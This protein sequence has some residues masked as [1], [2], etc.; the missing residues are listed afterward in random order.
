[1]YLQHALRYAC[2]AS[3][4]PPLPLHLRPSSP[5]LTPPPSPRPP[6]LVP[7]PLAC[8]C[9]S[10]VRLRAVHGAWQP[11]CPSGT[12]EVHDPEH[13]QATSYY[14]HL[15]YDGPHCPTGKGF[16]RLDAK[17]EVPVQ[18]VEHH[19]VPAPLL[20]NNNAHTN[21]ARDDWTAE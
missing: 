21:P 15:Q 5:L 10:P 14:Q 16:I 6:M 3:L 17:P 18:V 2:P 1:M 9:V 19:A 7:L 4:P 20:F 11:V 13:H 12:P 8:M